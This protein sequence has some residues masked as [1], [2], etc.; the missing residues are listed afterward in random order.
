MYAASDSLLVR[1]IPISTSSD[2]APSG[3]NARPPI[4]SSMRLSARSRDHVW[5]ST[6]DG[7]VYRVDWTKT[8]KPQHELDS[9]RTA[10]GTARAMVVAR[11]GGQGTGSRD[12][13]GAPARDAVI[14]LESDKKSGQ[15]VVTA[16]KAGFD[17]IVDGKPAALQSKTLFTYKKNSGNGNGGNGNQ[18]L[19]LLETGSTGGRALVGAIGDRIFVGGAS[20]SGAVAEGFD[21]LRYE[22]FSFAA[23]DLATTLDVKA[24]GAP[25]LSN[26]AKSDTS[27][28]TNAN[29]IVDVLVGG[30]RG[31]IYYYHDAIN[32]L[33]SV[34]KGKAD[35]D[36]LQPRMLHWHRKAV[37]A[38]KWS[39][40]G[41]SPSVYAF[42][43]EETKLTV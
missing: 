9:F 34:G 32:R 12:K 42:G 26:K 3:K 38:V 6:S 41:R 19:Q 8:P 43:V 4:I 21:Q 15:M 30:A 24:R 28:N 22:F 17:E 31:A 29:Q 14:I 7:R 35:K 33:T 25:S 18:G 20:Y 16:Y 13:A 37:H 10:S 2:A 39:R 5:V 1:R 23:P 11:V 27:V 36:G 40:D